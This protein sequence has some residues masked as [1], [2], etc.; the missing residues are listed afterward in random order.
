MKT[1]VITGGAKGI[2]EAVTK[3]L[4]ETGYRTVVV[5]F[6]SE[7]RALS[8]SSALLSG[9]GDNFILPCDVADPAQV[10]RC[11]EKIL[12][13]N[14]HVDALINNA[15]IAGQQL[16]QD[17]TDSEW[18]RMLGTNLSGV[19]HFTRAVLPDMLR[20]HSGRIV[21]IASMWGQVGASMEA[22]YSA[23]KAGVIGLTKA[24]AKETALSG[25]T[26]NCVAPGAIR[27]D[28]MKDFSPAEID[29]LCEEIPMGRLGTPEEV[30]AAVAFFLSDDAAYIT[31]QVL[32]VNGGMVV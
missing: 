22:A 9:G 14:G 1:A 28:M 12:R 8:L 29:A 7:E 16:L 13:M 3:K 23:S 27:T 30:A 6:H 17:V 19:F 10:N 20:R 26:V 25:I 18:D 15:G 31:G 5:Y 11:V 24:L 32:G 2:G 21:N 4:N